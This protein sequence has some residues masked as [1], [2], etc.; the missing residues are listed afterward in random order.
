MLKDWYTRGVKRSL[1]ER[2][3]G[4]EGKEKK[5]KKREKIAGQPLVSLQ[6]SNG[7]RDLPI[8]DSVKLGNKFTRRRVASHNRRELGISCLQSAGMFFF[9]LTTS[10]L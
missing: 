2:R 6:V 1:E 4:R 5:K 8:P 3:R 10:V 9:L 7:W